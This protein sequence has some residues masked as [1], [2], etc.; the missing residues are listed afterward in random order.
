MYLEPWILSQLNL[1]G[2]ILV[3]IIGEFDFVDYYDPITDDY[4]IVHDGFVE[5]KSTGDRKYKVAYKA[6]KTIGR[7]AYVNVL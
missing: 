3:P 6:I 7:V 4:Q 2:R 5:L 1:G